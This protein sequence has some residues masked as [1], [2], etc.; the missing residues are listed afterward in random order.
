MD[1]QKI[2]AAI[3]A[4]LNGRKYRDL[5]IPW[6]TAQ[7]LLE[8][9][10]MQGTR[11]PEAIKGVKAKL[12][13]IIA[14]Y[15]DTLDYDAAGERMRR[16]FESGGKEEIHTLCMDILR[17]HDSTRERLETYQAFFAYLF[18]H[19][20][21]ECTILDLACGLNPFFLPLIPFPVQMRY[22][23]Y[24]IHSPRI[25]LLNELFDAA[26]LPAKAIREDILIHPPQD[27]AD[28]VFLFK[29]AHRIEKRENGATRRL[30][31]S[32]NTHTIFLSLPTRSLNGRYPIQE[33]MQHL[34]EGILP[35]EAWIEE[36]VAFGA[37]TVYRIRKNDG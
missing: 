14:P 10:S 21:R 37:E 8:K 36:T 34:V 35:K 4:I 12:H 22:Q 33:R 11:L 20:G 30:I 5:D 31:Q 29:E 27:A 15:L 25:T 16:C 28:A 24:D 26:K 3:D 19:C 32:L 1:A 23:A 6:E 17:A 7:D 9:E 18:S 2:N 13:N